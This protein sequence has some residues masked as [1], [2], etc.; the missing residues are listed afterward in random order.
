MT[1]TELL[2]VD[3]PPRLKSGALA[4]LLGI[5]RAA[6]NHMVADGRLPQPLRLGPTL[7]LHDTAKVRVA[8]SKLQEAA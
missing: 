3:L 7:H 4:K 6:I 2:P 8:L 1:M 5:S